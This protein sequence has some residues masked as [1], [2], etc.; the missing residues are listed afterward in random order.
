MAEGSCLSEARVMKKLE[1][2]VVVVVVCDEVIEDV[3]ATELVKDDGNLMLGRSKSVS[4]LLG[5]SMEGDEDDDYEH[6]AVDGD[7]QD[8]FHL[9][10]LP[11]QV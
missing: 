6:V 4:G 3:D 7:V 11:W 5:R 1:D 9:Q 8:L 10:C 2:Y